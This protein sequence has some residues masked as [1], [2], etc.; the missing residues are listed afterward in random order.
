MIRVRFAPSPTGF[1]HIGGLRTCLY[2]WL[3]AKKNKGRLIL[4]IED[5]DRQRYVEGATENLIKTLTNVGL[6]WDE[7]PSLF[8]IKGTE[9]IIQKG[10]YGPYI[11]SQRAGNYQSLAQKLVDNEYAYYCFCAPEELKKMRQKQIEAKL[12]PM[13]DGRC[14]NLSK[15]EIGEY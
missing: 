2:N 15:K 4:R 11:Q 3:F 9:K 10:K 8:E 14:R 13:Y 7:G 6:S 5:T 1:L 12:P